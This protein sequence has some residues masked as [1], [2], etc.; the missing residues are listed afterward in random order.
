MHHFEN[1]IL[2]GKKIVTPFIW[3]VTK[4]TKFPVQ[5]KDLKV[6]F[7]N[8]YFCRIITEMS[9]IVLQ[10]VVL[11]KCLPPLLDLQLSVPSVVCH[12]LACGR[13]CGKLALQLAD[14]CGISF[15]RQ[16]FSDA[17]KR[18]RIFS[19][20]VESPPEDVRL[21]LVSRVSRLRQFCSCST[22]CSRFRL[23]T[24]VIFKKRI[25]T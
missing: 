8:K 6:V 13:S 5:S 17:L 4:Y 9:F 23:S 14:S 18:R 11:S 10:E 7:Q 20:V 2:R 1:A 3:Y 24:T 16:L 21:S 25:K 22:A 12:S 15:K 19:S